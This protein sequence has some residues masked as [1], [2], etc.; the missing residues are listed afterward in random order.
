MT[1]LFSFI[2]RDQQSEM[3][4]IQRKLKT[5]IENLNFTQSSLQR[6]KQ[7]LEG[8][9]TAAGAEI[10]GLKTSI[11]QLTSAN[12]GISAELD[13]TKVWQD[14]VTVFICINTFNASLKLIGISLNE[15]CDLVECL[16]V[17]GV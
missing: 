16:Y 6:Q 13:T 7:S 14:I 12:A 4:D 11:S 2:F 9:L 1:A 15:N 17:K 8:E 5:E 3:E 10:A